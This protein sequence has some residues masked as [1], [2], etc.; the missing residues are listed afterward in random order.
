MVHTKKL[1]IL[2]L[3][4]VM[5]MFFVMPVIG[6]A[7]AESISKG[8]KSVTGVVKAETDDTF[9]VETDSGN[10]T[11]NKNTALKHDHKMPGIGDE[12]TLIVDENNAVIEVHPKG[13]LGTH[14]FVTGKLVEVGKMKKEIKLLTDTGEQV[15]PIGRLEMKTKPIEEGAMVTVEVNESGMAIDLHRAKSDHKK[16]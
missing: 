15:F 13:E 12:L 3:P 2:M 1:R 4:V 8:H 16:H 11:I 14:R 6:D 10:L 9:T 5:G 7:G